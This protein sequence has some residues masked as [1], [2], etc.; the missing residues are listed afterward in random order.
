MILLKVLDNHFSTNGNHACFYKYTSRTWSKFS[1]NAVSQGNTA[2]IV[3][4]PDSGRNL[5]D[6]WVS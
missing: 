4:F 5:A 1:D 3:V 6:F 2:V